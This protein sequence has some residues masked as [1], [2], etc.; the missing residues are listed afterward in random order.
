MGN[1]PLSKEKDSG[2]RGGRRREEKKMGFMKF[3]LKC[4][5]RGTARL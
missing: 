5:L 3:R 2:E 1:S 4:Q